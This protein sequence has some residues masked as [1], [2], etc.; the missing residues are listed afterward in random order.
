M[1]EEEH[2][3]RTLYVDH[4]ELF[5]PQMEARKEIATKEAAQLCKILTTQFQLAP[6]S[7]KVLDAC[8]GI[9]VHAVGLSSEGFE[10][11][12][13]DLSPHCLRQAD[14]RAKQN[15]LNSSR[16]RL[17]QGDVRQVSDVL[18]EKGERDFNVILS[19]GNSLGFYE[20]GDDLQILQQLHDL[21]S[22]GCVL[23][24][25]II[26]KEWL[27]RHF[28]PRGFSQISRGI[29]MDAE[30]KLNLETSIV[31]SVWKFYETRMPEARNNKFMLSLKWRLRI[32]SFE[33][34]TRLLTISGWDYVKGFGSISSLDP[35][36]S[37]SY[38]MVFICRKNSS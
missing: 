16:I 12:G 32:Y 24:I 8:C 5:L 2:W 26:N 35:Q 10:V 34:F 6:R 30:R 11:V 18:F 1:P 31:E 22:P 19:I 23:V 29:Q 33:E 25:D 3:T 14:R 38:H 27:V 15:E 20:K 4:P 17:Y 13:F 9:G 7:T 36:T 37:D 28:S 21:A